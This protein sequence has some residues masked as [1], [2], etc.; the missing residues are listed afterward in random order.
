MAIVADISFWDEKVGVAEIKEL[1]YGDISSSDNENRLVIRW[2]KFYYVHDDNGY[3]S[4]RDIYEDD[5]RSGVSLKESLAEIKNL[6]TMDDD[7][8]E[9][10]RHLSLEYE[11][12]SDG[13]LI[14]NDV[15]KYKKPGMVEV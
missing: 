3:R 2:I 7:E 9:R 10:L 6:R 15:S 14:H 8:V 4:K 5:V 12:K 11:V 13:T 1:S